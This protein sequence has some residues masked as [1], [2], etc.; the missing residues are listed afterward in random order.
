M[1]MKIDEMKSIEELLPLFCDGTLSEKDHARVERW[2][3]EDEANRRVLHDML[4]LCMDLDALDVMSRIDADKA[5]RRVNKR[6]RSNRFNSRFGWFRNAAAVMFI[7]L[8]GAVAYLAYELSPSEQMVADVQTLEFRTNPGMTGKVVLPDGTTAILNSGSVLSYPSE[9]VGTE[10]QVRFEGEGY[11]DVTTDKERPFVVTTSS[12]SAVR[13]YGTEFNLEAYAGRPC[14]ATLVSGE[15]GF[16]YMERNGQ[17]KEMALEPDQRLTY[18][19]WDGDVEVE[20]T[21][22]V[23]E[24]AWKDGK[25]ML[26]KTPMKQ[27]LQCL[28]KRYD[29]E[30]VVRDKEIEGY[31]FSGGLISM[32]RLEQLLDSFSISSNFKWRYLPSSYDLHEK[33][34]IE[35]YNLKNN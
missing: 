22:C 1:K 26:D 28:S 16:L 6:I 29:V 7:P 21:D 8:L 5:F 19:P 25:I 15:V 24:T 14:V 35:I 13:V 18:N 4:G 20:D 9:F 3:E 31:T 17:K 2:L 12:N 10:R 30:F 34:R 33:Q 32:N 23:S 11:F 27:I